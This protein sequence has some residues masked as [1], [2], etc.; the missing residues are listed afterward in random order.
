MLSVDQ[1]REFDHI[2]IVKDAD[3]EVDWQKIGAGDPVSAHIK[4]R[5]DP[6]LVVDFI[7]IEQ[8]YMGMDLVLYPFERALCVPNA[9]RKENA[10]L[11][12]RPVEVR[13]ANSAR[14]TRFLQ[15]NQHFLGFRVVRGTVAEF[16]QQMNVG[17]NDQKTDLLGFFF[18]IPYDSI[19]NNT[20][21]AKTTVFCKMFQ[22]SFL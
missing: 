16:R 14:N 20:R 2:P 22:N 6:G 1:I 13:D 19:E 7:G 21:K 12:T 8:M 3:G 4:I 9:A 10:I 17:I 18:I 5:K 11:H 15:G